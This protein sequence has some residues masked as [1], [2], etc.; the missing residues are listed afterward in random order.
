MAGLSS[1]LTPCMATHTMET[2]LLRT[3]CE[4]GAFHGIHCLYMVKANYAEY[5]SIRVVMHDHENTR[6]SLA[7]MAG[8]V[9]ALSHHG[10]CTF[11]GLV[12]WG[13]HGSSAGSLMTCRTADS[14]EYGAKLCESL[15]H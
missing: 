1:T 4:Y 7:T 11:N 6:D 8:P 12:L 2:S 14:C 10:K 15:T 9:L 13:K 3:V 5:N